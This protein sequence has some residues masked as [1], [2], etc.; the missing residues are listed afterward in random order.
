MDGMV[1]PDW[2]GNCGRHSLTHSL[3]RL[4]F[5]YFK[6]ERERERD[7]DYQKERKN[8]EIERKRERERERGLEEKSN[9]NGWNDKKEEHLMPQ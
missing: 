3:T 4:P 9:G 6:L 2:G 7:K 8:K 5:Q 1:R